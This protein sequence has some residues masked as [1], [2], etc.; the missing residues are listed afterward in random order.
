M[1]RK[2][3]KT[4]GTNWTVQ[5]FI[6]LGFLFFS[7][8]LLSALVILAARLPLPYAYESYRS[9]ILPAGFAIIF[10]L[11]LAGIVAWGL[12]STRNRAT[13]L[14]EVFQPYGLAGKR[15]LVNGHQYHGMIDGRQV[16]IYIYHGPVLDIY[17]RTS[18]LTRLVVKQK[19]I[20]GNMVASLSQPEHL[21]VVEDLPGNIQ[22]S[23]IDPAWAR[24]LFSYTGVR[25][26]VTRLSHTPGSHEITQVIFQPEALLLRRYRTQLDR[27]TSDDFQNWMRDLT[28]LLDVAES[29]PP[30]ILPPKPSHFGRN[31]HH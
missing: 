10:V 2:I 11:V 18:V 28:E 20:A 16:D 3:Q 19:G 23:A 4:W 29:L 15:Y 22:M 27:I 12:L 1:V 7:F 14:D 5:F 21:S 9:L 13:Q 30:P 25:D 8:V 6:A 17:L 26:A 24:Q 31:G